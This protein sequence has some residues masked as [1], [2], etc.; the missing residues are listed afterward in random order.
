MTLSDYVQ[1]FFPFKD[2]KDI[3]RGNHLAHQATKTTTAFLPQFRWLWSGVDYTLNEPLTA[4][5]TAP[6]LGFRLAR[7]GLTVNILRRSQNG[8]PDASDS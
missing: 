6:L 3:H 2:L 5:R 7:D 4:F 8:Q 1:G